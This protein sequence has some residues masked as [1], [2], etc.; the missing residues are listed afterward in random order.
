MLVI[1]FISVFEYT[2]FCFKSFFSIYHM[3]S[4]GRIFIYNTSFGP[5]KFLAPLLGTL[6]GLW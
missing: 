6:D 4:F 3:Y 1:L 2:Y 5:Y